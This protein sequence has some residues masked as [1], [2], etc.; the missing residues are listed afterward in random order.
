MKT[1]QRASDV[2]WNPIIETL[3]VEKMRELQL[4]KFKRILEWAYERSKFHR[5]LYQEAGL[6]P[7]DIK[8][9]EDVAKVPKVEKA[10]M[11]ERIPSLMEML[12]VCLWKRSR[13]FDRPVEQPDHPFISQILGRTGSGGPN[14]GLTS[15]M[16]KVIEKRTEYSFP[17]DI[18]SLSPSGQVI[19]RLK[20][21]VVKSS[22][23]ESSIQK[24]VFLKS[25]NFEPPP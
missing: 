14:P 16:H 1:S 19:M 23:A 10:M 13:N 9:Y 3:P 24:L 12:S 17:L 22:Q 11:R 15:S 7:G 6:E 2:Y 18:I 5:K 20:R 21:L 8:S 25:R 4:K